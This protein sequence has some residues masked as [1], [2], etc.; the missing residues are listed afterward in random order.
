MQRES[1]RLA[2]EWLLRADRE[3]LIAQRALAIFGVGELEL[4]SEDPG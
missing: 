2:P 4:S 1:R 3:I